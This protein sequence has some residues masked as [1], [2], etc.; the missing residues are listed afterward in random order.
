MQL[1]NA[2]QSGLLKTYIFILGAVMTHYFQRSVGASVRG[3]MLPTNKTQAELLDLK[4][5]CLP[6]RI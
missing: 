1:L 5:I 6:T 4:A 3:R 2:L